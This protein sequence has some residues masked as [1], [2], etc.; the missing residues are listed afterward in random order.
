MISVVACIFQYTDDLHHQVSTGPP[1][2]PEKYTKGSSRL[3]SGPSR[4]GTRDCTFLVHKLACG[5]LTAML[6]HL[7]SMHVFLPQVFGVFDGP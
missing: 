1:E 3:F 2:L 4:V 5:H 6:P 7:S